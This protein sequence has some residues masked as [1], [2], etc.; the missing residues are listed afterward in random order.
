MDLFVI[1]APLK[2]RTLE[3]ILKRLGFSA[4]VQATKGHLFDMP[5]NLDVPAIDSRMREFRRTPKD[6]EV[7]KRLRS[8]AMMAENV[9]IATDADAEG[10][11]IA[12]DVATL[13]RDMHPNPLRV[14]MKGLDDDSVRASID[15]ATPVRKADAVAGR[16][17]AIVDRL[18]G[19]SFSRPDVGVGRVQTALL[20]LVQRDKP[21]TLRLNLVAPAK[22]GGRVFMAEAPCVAPFDPEIARRLTG[23]AFPMISAGATSTVASP[24][25]HMGDV[26]VRAAEKLGMSPRETDDSMQRLYEQGRL[27][28][29]RA[30]SRGVAPATAAKIEALLRKAGYNVDRNAMAPKTEED[31]HD[32]PFPIGGKVDLTTNPQQLGHDEG[33]RAQIARDL[34][35][36]G[37]RF[38]SQP[39][40]GAELVPFLVKSGFSQAVA[41]KVG[42]LDW[43]RENGP[44]FP[45]QVTWVSGSSLETRRADAVLL[46]AAIGAKLG[47]PSTWAKHIE[48]FME[49]NLVDGDL[50]LT[51]RGRAWISKSPPGL[52]DPRVSAAIEYACERPQPSAFGNPDR[53]PWEVNAEQ[54]VRSLPEPLRAPLQA[55]VANE[56]PRAKIDPISD[57]GFDRSVMADMD[58]LT[59]THAPAPIED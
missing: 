1:E 59:L 57:F 43:R 36:T 30:G 56:A 17:R 15:A 46:E 6:V 28:Y 11:V 27:S 34:V 10:D 13:I 16:T 29:P 39:G 18:I 45:G 37:L 52:L 44:R 19:A 24:A 12:W 55:M 48:R 8:E 51:D 53:E 26:M 3:T 23:M 49:R 9:I 7:V 50:Q 2:A 40:I 20:G 14:R 5:E 21:S 54:I 42:S 32:A 58:G 31:V 35:K 41:E 47:R 25:P 38:T 4:K 33:V 22:D